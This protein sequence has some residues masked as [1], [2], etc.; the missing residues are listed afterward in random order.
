MI[1]K[2]NE[3]QRIYYVPFLRLFRNK[4]E[5]KKRRS[6]DRFVSFCE[7]PSQRTP[8]QLYFDSGPITDRLVAFA[9]LTK[10]LESLLRASSSPIY[11]YIHIYQRNEEQSGFVKTLRDSYADNLLPRHIAAKVKT[12]PTVRRAFAKVECFFIRCSNKSTVYEMNLNPYNF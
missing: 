9:F 3:L 4:K 2:K 8:K 11:I 12:E 1:L 5:K 6:F 10:R 7:H